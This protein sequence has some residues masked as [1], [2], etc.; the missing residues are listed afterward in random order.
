VPLF[1][2][3][4]IRS[5]PNK[6]TAV[7]QKGGVGPILVCVGRGAILWLPSSFA[8]LL[9]AKQAPFTALAFGQILVI[10]MWAIQSDQCVV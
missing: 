6:S 4:K 7:N 8:F 9:H 5:D 2:S 3:P 1:T 10:H